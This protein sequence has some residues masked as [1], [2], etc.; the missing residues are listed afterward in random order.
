VFV[1]FKVNRLL[2]RSPVSRW[3]GKAERRQ[4][5][6]SSAIGS[7]IDPEQLGTVNR[8]FTIVVEFARTVSFFGLRFELETGSRSGQKIK[9]CG[10]Q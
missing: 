9:R 5:R 6:N 1:L 3:L 4:R 7:K 8:L 10:S 2:R